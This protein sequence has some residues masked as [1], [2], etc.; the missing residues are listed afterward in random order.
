MTNTKRKAILKKLEVIK[1]HI[2][3]LSVLEPEFT[4]QYLEQGDKV[5]AILDDLK[6]KV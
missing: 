3:N 1:D 2:E 4:K 5:I 6:N